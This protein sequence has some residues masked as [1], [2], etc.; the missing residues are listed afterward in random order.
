MGAKL[1]IGIDLDGVITPIGLINPSV[2]MPRWLYIFIVP[3]I[4]WMVANEK[5]ELKK[6]AANHQIIIVSARPAWCKKLTA[7]W[8]KYHQIPF[9]KLY[10]VGFGKGTKQRKLRVIKKEKIEVF[11]DDNRRVTDFL[12]GNSINAVSDFASLSGLL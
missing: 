6:I 9:D 12:K 2:K 7:Q 10:C 5:E 8:L 11:I 3:V 1:K 4:L